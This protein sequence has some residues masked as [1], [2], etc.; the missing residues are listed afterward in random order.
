AWSLESLIVFRVLQGLGGGGLAPS[1]QSIIADAFP[2]EKRGQAFALY[3]VAVVV[4]PVIGPTLGGWITDNYSW[5]WVFLINVPMGVLSLVL[6]WFIVEE[7]ESTQAERR[8]L[9]EGGVK[10]DYLG[11]LFVVLALGCLEVVLDEG[12]RQDWYASSFIVAFAIVSVASFTALIVWEWFHEEPLV[13]VRLIFSRH[14]GSCFA[15]MLGVGAL[16]ISTT[17]FLPQLLQ[18]RFGYDAKLAGLALLPGGIATLVLMPVAGILSGKVQPRVLI[19]F[20]MGCAALAMWWLTGLNGNADFGFAAWSRVFLGL[21]LPFMFIPIT[22]AS[23]DGLPP[24]KTNQASG[25]INVARNVGGSIGVSLAQTLLAQRNQFHQS[26]L[27]EHIAP[28]DTGYQQGLQQTMRYFEAQGASSA[29]AAQRATAWIAQL[30]QAQ[31]D[32]LS[33]IDVF[34]TLSTIAGGSALMALLLKT[35]DLKAKPAGH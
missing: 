30:V 7:P 24:A 29:E 3:G 23:Y 14:F 18:T 26:R 35:V 21:G 2:P 17:Q 6:T 28:S 8:K 22:A 31:A 5:H 4:A 34:W 27:V 33:Y 25:L 13:D 1:E 16:L 32:L 9:L 10:F 15:V 20:G 19:G 11:C 12:Q